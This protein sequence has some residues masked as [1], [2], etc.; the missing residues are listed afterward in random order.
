MEWNMPKRKRL[1]FVLF[2][3]TKVP[4]SHDSRETGTTAS[5]NCDAHP[6]CKVYEGMAYVR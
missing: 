4:R 3:Q 1:P 5:D 6:D 2:S